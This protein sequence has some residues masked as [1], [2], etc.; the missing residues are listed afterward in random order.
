MGLAKVRIKRDGIAGEQLQEKLKA[1]NHIKVKEINKQLNSNRNTQS[2]LCVKSPFQTN[3]M[4]RETD[5][6]YCSDPFDG[7]LIMTIVEMTSTVFS[8]FCVIIAER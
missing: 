4:L 2:S 8:L 1:R 5:F 3:I 7:L 6:F